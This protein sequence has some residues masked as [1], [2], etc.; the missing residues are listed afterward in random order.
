ME[1]KYH[2]NDLIKNY[3]S[4]NYKNVMMIC[5]KILKSNKDISEVYN[6]YGLALQNLNRHK[7]AINYFAKTI[8]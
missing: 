5:E 3:Q 4:K 2:M 8:S 6:F 1:L 7:Q